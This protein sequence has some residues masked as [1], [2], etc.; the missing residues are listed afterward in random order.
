MQGLLLLLL[1]CRGPM[2]WQ[3]LIP[4]WTTSLD[5]NTCLIWAPAWCMNGTDIKHIKCTHKHVVKQNIDWDKKFSNN[6]AMM[7]APSWLSLALYHLLTIAWCS[8]YR[9]FLNIL[10]KDSAI[11]KVVDCL[12]KCNIGIQPIHCL[13]SRDKIIEQFSDSIHSISNISIMW[14]LERVGFL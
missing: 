10:H 11:L 2:H 1:I 5:A 12:I 13:A 3:G 6:F 4:K 8:S 14:V 7:V 9:P